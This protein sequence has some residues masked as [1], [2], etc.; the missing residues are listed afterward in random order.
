MKRLF[1]K[2]ISIGILNLLLFLG[3]FKLLQNENVYLNTLGIISQN[4]E[5]SGDWNNYEIKKVSKPYIKIND[6]NLLNWDASIYNC[7][8]ER[9]YVVERDCY[10]HV[11]SAFFP[12][13]PLIWRATNSSPKVISV[14]NYLIFVISIAILT[15]H[16]L[17]T[18]DYKMMMIFAVLIT[19]PS[20]IIYYIPYTEALFLLTM[21]IAAIGI[22]KNKY[23][24]Y[25][26]GFLLLAMVRP[27]TVFGLLAILATEMF[28]FF[29]HKQVKELFTNALFKSLPFILGFFF[30]F[31]IQYLYSGTWT[32]FVNATKAWSGKI[33]AFTSI[34]DWSVEGFGM[35]SFALFFVAIPATVF[36]GYS[37]FNFLG[38]NVVSLKL[39]E[40]NP[41]NYLLIMSL[42]YLSGIML[43][44]LITSGGNLHSF[45]RFTLVSP[46]FYIAFIQLLNHIS[47]F[48]IKQIIVTFILFSLPLILFL[49]LTSYGGSRFEFS[50]VGLYLLTLSF[51]YLGIKNY[52]CKTSDYISF[53]LIIFS[54]IV[55][56]TYLFNAY[57]SNSWVFT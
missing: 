49:S 2:L 20:T 40:N 21:T 43:F 6:D 10:G 37:I 4:Y 46:F 5:R 36:L 11:R 34:T 27:A 44:T 33:Q 55:W 39:T 42:F 12:L 1:G 13:F 7:L 35:N 16:L 31:L 24:I 32:S 38:K 41:S 15:L 26:I 22:L 50:F 19:L 23:W 14:I 48:K 52:L 51:L 29:R 53:S 56:N 17:K 8:Q 18:S 57:L 3:I 54:N 45:F 47:K 30:S 28:M 25:F 9:M